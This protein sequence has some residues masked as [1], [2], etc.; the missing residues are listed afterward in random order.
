MELLED[1]NRE[2]KRFRPS[3]AEKIKLRNAGLQWTLSSNV[4]AVGT[5][6]DD[7]IIRFINGSLYQYPNQGKLFDKMM[8]SNSKGHFVWVKLRKPKV[9]YMKI[10]ALPLDSDAQVSDDE[11]MKLVDDRGKATDIKL[12]ELGIFIPDFTDTLN[13]V[14]LN[15]LLG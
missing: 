4:S 10:G 8:A 15:V 5:V 3:P 6:G 11:L 7:L 2:Y 1:K 14:G 12:R 13:L 9:A